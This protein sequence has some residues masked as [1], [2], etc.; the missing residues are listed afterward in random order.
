MTNLNKLIKQRQGEYNM[1]SIEHNGEAW[2]R[3]IDHVELT[4][5]TH[6]ATIAE[7]VRIAEGMI[8]K[9]RVENRDSDLYE[10]SY[11]LALTDLIEAITSNKE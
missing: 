10:R 3:L 1:P 2:I 8:E 6:Q 5:Q 4:T 7:V 9:E 11:T